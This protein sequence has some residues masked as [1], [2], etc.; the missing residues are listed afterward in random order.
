MDFEFPD[1]NGNPYKSSGGEMVYCAEVDG[2]V[3]EG[4]RIVPIKD[5]CDE[6]RNGATPNRGVLEYWNR[7]DIPWLKTG[8]VSNNIAIKSEEYISENGFKNSS[9]KVLPINTVLMAMYGATA[10]QIAFL[11]FETT[12]N[13]ACCGMICKSI[14][15]ASFLYYHFL[16]NQKEIANMATG[17]AQPNL[18][19]NLIED[20]LIT[21]PTEKIMNLHPLDT[22][23]EERTKVTKENELLGQLEEL[24]LARMTM[25][26][27]DVE[28]I[29]LK[30]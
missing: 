18:S 11:K 30:Q 29:Q 20:L 10:G 2:E 22:I 28:I 17:G 15:E 24:V 25:V 9:T 5:F 4:W 26:E 3:P 8:E 6:M 14:K 1:E 16:V 23:I 19:K 21:L 13:Q 7:P 27:N 12:T